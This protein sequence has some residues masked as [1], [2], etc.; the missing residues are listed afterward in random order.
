MEEIGEKTPKSEPLP[1]PPKPNFDEIIK[2]YNEIKKLDEEN[3]TIRN[4][5]KIE[6][7][8]QKVEQIVRKIKYQKAKKKKRTK[9]YKLEEESIDDILDDTDVFKPKMAGKTGLPSFFFSNLVS[10][11]RSTFQ[12]AQACNRMFYKII[13]PTKISDQSL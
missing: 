11:N 12:K 7:D 9:K 3:I 10:G 6:I 4:A 13:P 2:Q 1:E 5:V 8:E